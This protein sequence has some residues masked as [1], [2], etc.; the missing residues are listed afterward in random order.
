MDK[1]LLLTIKVD[2]S[3]AS[4]VSVFSNM[5]NILK[6]KY[7]STRLIIDATEVF[8]KQPKLDL[9]APPSGIQLTK[10]FLFVIYIN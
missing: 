7:S 10:F 8:V 3:V 9:L 5:P 4:Q 6:K 2:P 1:L